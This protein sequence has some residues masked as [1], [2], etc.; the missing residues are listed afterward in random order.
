MLCVARRGRW[1]RPANGT[2]WFYRVRLERNGDTVGVAPCTCWLELQKFVV[3]DQPLQRLNALVEE[4]EI[5]EVQRTL[6]GMLADGQALEALRRL[7][8]GFLV[9]GIVLW[10]K[11]RHPRLF[12]DVLGTL[13][14]SLGLLCALVLGKNR[15]AGCNYR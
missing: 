12:W 4:L 14:R 2:H 9:M 11:R 5:P 8:S 3:F 15:G 13:R 10:G 7:Y 6:P 1:G